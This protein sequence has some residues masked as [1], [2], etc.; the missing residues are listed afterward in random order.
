MAGSNEMEVT[1]SHVQKHMMDTCSKHGLLEFKHE[2]DFDVFV[3]KSN[4]T[5]VSFWLEAFHPSQLRMRMPSKPI[6][7]P[8]SIGGD[9]GYAELSTKFKASHGKT[10]SLVV[11]SRDPKICRFSP[12]SA[13]T[14]KKLARCIFE[15]L[16][17][18]F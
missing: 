3:L 13:S 8:A 11:D 10:N 4:L 16:Y 15:T 5:T 18:R 2:I 17:F 9:D 14:Q 1:L 6:L 12:N 7:T